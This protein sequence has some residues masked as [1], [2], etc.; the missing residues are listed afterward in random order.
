MTDFKELIAEFEAA[1]QSGDVYKMDKCFDKMEAHG[2]YRCKFKRTKHAYKLRCR[3]Y[4]FG[5]GEPCPDLSQTKEELKY[6]MFGL[7]SVWLTK[8]MIAERNEQLKQ[9]EDNIELC[10]IL[11]QY[12]HIELQF[13]EYWVHFSRIW[14]LKERKVLHKNL[15]NLCEQIYHL[16][17][18]NHLKRKGPFG[19][20]CSHPLVNLMT[21]DTLRKFEIE[22]PR[23]S[24]W[25]AKL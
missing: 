1:L 22:H 24:D 11:K 23:F 8:R 18:K 17:L 4:A 16:V 6:H 20:E 19:F 14:Y 25:F 5:L 12:Y 2:Q 21:N 3:Y 15:D 10:R 13:V 9:Y 7:H